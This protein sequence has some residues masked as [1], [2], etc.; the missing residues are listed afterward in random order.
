MPLLK[1]YDLMNFTKDDMFDCAIALRNSS[2]N[3]K[4]MEEAA[5]RIVRYLYGNF[6]D[7][8]TGKSACTLVRFFKT[9]P[10]AELPP[11]LQGAARELLKGDAIEP[12]TKCLTL[13]ATAGDE[14]QWN[15]RG[16]STGHKA[17]PLVSENFVKDIPMIS[18]L[19]QQFG[20]E[21]STVL[22]PMPS[23]LIDSDRK[24]HSTFIFHVPEALGSRYIPAQSEFVVPYR[25]RSILGFGGLLPSGDLFAVIMFGKT[26]IP[27]ETAT[28]FKWV[29]T[30]VWIAAT[31]FD[32]KAVFTESKG[33]KSI[34]G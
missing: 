12:P 15:S 7:P 26:W 16:G 1:M 33:E 34:F 13:L 14:P 23:L 24:I 18:R 28:L 9:H 10:Y 31:A 5:E 21:I 19:I 2:S 3:A 17:I 29:S 6:V 22:E 27:Q 20:L 30:C 8:S 11:E 25:V 32:R 4:S